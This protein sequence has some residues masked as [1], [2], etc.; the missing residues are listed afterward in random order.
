MS[1]SGSIRASGAHGIK[2]LGDKLVA[3]GLRATRQRLA[4]AELLFSR[5]DRHISAEILFD[6]A[7]Q[8][9][10]PI[11]LA[12]V[13]NTLHQFSDVGLLRAIAIDTER[14]YFDTNTG[15]HQHFFIEET[16]EVVDIPDSGLEIGN[17]PEPPAGFEI[18]RVDV[19]VRL[20]ALPR[21]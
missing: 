8:A 1:E 18:S 3:A 10:F 6:E 9:G 12:T 17:L 5:G 21:Q 19:V 15:N 16:S 7:R 14:T 4:L 13:Y 20:R 11:S 2:Q